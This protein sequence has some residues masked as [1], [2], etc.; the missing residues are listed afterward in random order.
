MVETWVLEGRAPM[1]LANSTGLTKDTFKPGTKVTV[2]G[3]PPTGEPFRGVG[4]FR[5]LEEAL[6]YSPDAVGY[7]KTKHVLQ[8]GDI[9]LDT[10]EVKRF[11]AGPAF[12]SSK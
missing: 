12:G 8:T 2:I 3:Y 11:G 1:V 7:L 6:A 9:R 10:G 4:T 5:S